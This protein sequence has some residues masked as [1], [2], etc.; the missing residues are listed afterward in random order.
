LGVASVP[1]VL[2]KR[3][4]MQSLPQMDG[5]A[6]LSIRVGTAL[7]RALPSGTVVATTLAG[8]AYF[9]KDATVVDQWG[10]ND[11]FVAHMRLRQFIEVEGF[12]GRGHL[13][14][15]PM[16]YLRSKG[17]NLYIEHPVICSCEHPCREDKPDVFVRLG[18]GNECVRA[19]YMTQTPD[20]TR[21]F[22]AH[23]DMFVLDNVVCPTGDRGSLILPNGSAF[24]SP[25]SR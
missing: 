3:F 13:K 19:W 7:D 23:P 17:V 21:W 12:N 6:H 4:G 16:P 14:Y 10:L 8:M 15:A 20:L 18:S 1:A 25:R 22:C 5:Y 2:E 9:M 24:S 11:S